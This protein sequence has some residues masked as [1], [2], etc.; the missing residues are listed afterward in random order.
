MEP[1]STS[2][3]ETPPGQGTGTGHLATMH[4]AASNPAKFASN[5]GRPPRSAPWG[6]RSSCCVTTSWQ[7]EHKHTVHPACQP[8][9]S[10][11]L[12]FLQPDSARCRPGPA[13]LRAS[14]GPGRQL[15]L[16]SQPN[17]RWTSVCDSSA[18][19]AWFALSKLGH[20]MATMLQ[21]RCADDTVARSCQKVRTCPPLAVGVSYVT[22]WPAQ[23][24]HTRREPHDTPRSPTTFGQVCGSPPWLAQ[25]RGGLFS[26]LGCKRL[27]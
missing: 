20:R 11:Y 2:D 14:L 4:A 9:P 24:E 18:S 26:A 23:K 1:L 16:E 3:I 12:N 13:S 21:L 17:Q 27:M 10:K 25:S 6:S 22:T 7:H 5:T 8:P 19:A 15:Y